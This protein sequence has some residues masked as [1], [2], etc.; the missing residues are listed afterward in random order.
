LAY[1][2]IVGPLTNGTFALTH[3][4]GDAG[5]ADATRPLGPIAPGHYTTVYWLISYPN[6]DKFGHAV[7]GPSVKPDDDLWLEYDVWAKAVSAGT[8]REVVQT[9]RVTMR[10]EISAMANKIQ[11]NAANKVPQEYKDLLNLYVPTWT[12]SAADGTP[13]SRVTAEGVWYDLGN[14]G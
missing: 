13:G 5:L 7:W 4:G 2:S 9:R 3:E 12:N 6:V 14:I 10:N 8:P 1:P 11:P